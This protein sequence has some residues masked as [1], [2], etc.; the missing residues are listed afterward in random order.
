METGDRG[1]QAVLSRK[2][3]DRPILKEVYWSRVINPDTFD[4]GEHYPVAG[5]IQL[6]PL[7]YM[8]KVRFKYLQCAGCYDYLIY[9]KLKGT[10]VTIWSFFAQVI[11]PCHQCVY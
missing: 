8:P 11:C 1:R 7:Y 9:S 5:I 2:Q 6:F 4:F 10:V 3:T